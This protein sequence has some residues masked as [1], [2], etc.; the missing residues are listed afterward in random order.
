MKR[1]LFFILSVVFIIGV[2]VSCATKKLLAPV[3]IEKTRE[4][5]K[6]LKDTIY[7]V[8]ADSSY[9]EAYIEC[10]NGKPVLRET[11]ETLKNSRSGK[12][13]STPKATLTGNKLN[14]E[15]K[16][17]VEELF[18]QW[19]ETYIKE[20]EQTPIYVDKPVEV[21]K[22]LTLFQKIQIWLG[23]FFLLILAIV[24]LAFILRWKKII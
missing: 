11:P 3:T 18:K 1:I 10:I 23:R 7:K 4:V 9:Y 17:Q 8:E 16:K 12:S 21:E 22:P 6:I 13:L 24:A 2:V 20:H 15:C 14:V 19:Q 5:T